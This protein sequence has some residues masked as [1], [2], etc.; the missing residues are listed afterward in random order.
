MRDSFGMTGGAA[1]SAPLRGRVGRIIAAVIVLTSTAACSGGAEDASLADRFSAARPVAVTAA[2]PAAPDTADLPWV[3]PPGTV[4]LAAGPFSDVLRW[5]T[6]SLQP[7]PQPVVTGTLRSTVDVAPLLQLTV[8]ASFYDGA[9][10]YLGQGT[11]VQEG[12]GDE[13]V[14][15]HDESSLPVTGSAVRVAPDKAFAVEA[16]SAR[17]AVTQFVTE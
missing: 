11:F 12:H 2:S 15:G 16:V 9:G 4:T 10:R 8:R 7:G 6:V 17:L 14:A 5:E 13:S 3:P 1:A